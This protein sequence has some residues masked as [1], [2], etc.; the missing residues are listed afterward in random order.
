[1]YFFLKVI[2]TNRLNIYFFEKFSKV[3]VINRLN[4]Y[5][6]YMLLYYSSLLEIFFKKIYDLC[7]K[8]FLKIKT[9]IK[10]RMLV[11]IVSANT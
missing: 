8:F 3:M 5:N 6:E 1:M 10:S 11:F 4:I 7:K 2:V 9:Y